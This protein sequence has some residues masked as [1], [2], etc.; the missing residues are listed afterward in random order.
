MVAAGQRRVLALAAVPALPPLARGCPQCGRLSCAEPTRGLPASPSPLGAAGT[1]IP[2]CPELGDRAEKRNALE[3]A[4]V[5]SGSSQALS[6]LLLCPPHPVTTRQAAGCSAWSGLRKSNSDYPSTRF[7]S[8]GSPPLP[9]KASSSVPPPRLPLLVHPPV[10]Q[11]GTKLPKNGR[12]RAG[13]AFTGPRGP[14][15]RAG[16]RSGPA[17]RTAAPG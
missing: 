1:Q 15:R 7:V 6:P 9:P 13:G 3:F 4:R 16:S 11:D 10:G 8:R 2:H 14:P 12:R 17:P 5:K